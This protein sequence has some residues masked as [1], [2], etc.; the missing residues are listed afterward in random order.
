VSAETYVVVSNGKPSKLLD[1]DAAMTRAKHLG[2]F[3]GQRVEVHVVRDGKTA[4]VVA[5]WDKFRR[6]T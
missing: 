3:R 6:R 2:E 5:M 4:D 1:W